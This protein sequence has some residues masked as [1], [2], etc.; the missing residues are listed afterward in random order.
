MFKEV[1]DIQTADMLNLPVPKANYHS[2]ILK[3]SELQ[4]EMVAELAK[5]AE[6]I[7]NKQVRSDVDNMLL[8]TNDGRKLALDQRMLNPLLPDSDTSKT[9]A[10]ADNVFETWQ[11]SADQCSAQM[12][13]CDR[14][15]IRCYK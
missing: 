2:V 10:C 9:S 13:F 15:A 11:R 8:V 6:R 3:P 1:A 7:R 14:A 12:I 5:R 4:Q